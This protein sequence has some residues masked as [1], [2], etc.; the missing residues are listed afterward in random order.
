[1]SRQRGFIVLI[2]ENVR[3]GSLSSLPLNHGLFK[4]YDWRPSS[5]LR[6]MLSHT[7]SSHLLR[8]VHGE[9]TRIGRQSWNS[10]GTQ[11][12]EFQLELTE[13]SI[14]GCMRNNGV[15]LRKRR[16]IAAG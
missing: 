13:G 10:H 16:S 3:S 5:S 6:F 9:Y 8:L 12:G 4:F 1:M 15:Y 11:R 7:A 2:W 14:F